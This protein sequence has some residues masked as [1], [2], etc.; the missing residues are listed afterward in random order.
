MVTKT[1]D[2]YTWEPTV[3]VAT[4]L[5]S[6][7][8]VKPARSVASLNKVYDVVV[9]G[10]GYAGLSAARDLSSL[11]TFVHVSALWVL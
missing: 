9:I 11:R 8:V 6:D 5:E 3:G 1:S 7:A 10:A 4:G 2:G